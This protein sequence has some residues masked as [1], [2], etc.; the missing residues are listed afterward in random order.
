MP[1]PWLKTPF[2]KLL[3]LSTHFERNTLCYDTPHSPVFFR[4]PS[5]FVGRMPWGRALHADL[6]LEEPRWQR[7]IVAGLVPEPSSALLALCGTFYF[8]MRRKRELTA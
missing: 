2:S 6:G 1:N 3:K 7:A 4:N 8:V 5:G